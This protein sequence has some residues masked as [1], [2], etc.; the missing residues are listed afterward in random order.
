MSEN[1]QIELK[2]INTEEP[3]KKKKVKKDVISKIMKYQIVAEDKEIYSHLFDLFKETRQ[4]LNNTVNFMYEWSELKFLHKEKYGNY[5]QPNEIL[6]NKRNSGFYKSEQGYIDSILAEKYIK[7]LSSN[8]TSAVQKAVQHWKTNYKD[9][10][11][12]TKTI[13]FYKASNKIYLHNR[14]INIYQEDKEYYIDVSLFSNIY[15]KEKNFKSSKHLFKLIVGDNN[16]KTIV[17]RILNEEYGVGES[18]LI[19]DKKNKK[20]FV[21]L[22]YQFKKKETTSDEYTNILGVN[23]GLRFAAYI[24]INKSKARFKIVG[25]E[26]EA[27]RKQVDS[28]I[29]KK[30]NQRNVAGDGS[31]N[32]GKSTFLK[33]VTNIRKQTSNFTNL[34][35]HRYSKYIVQLAVRYKCKEIRLENLKGMNQKSKYLRSWSYYDIRQKIIYKAKE[36][37]IKVILIDPSYTTQT[38]SQCEHISQDNLETRK[39]FICKNCDFRTEIDYNAALNIANPEFDKIKTVKEARKEFNKDDQITDEKVDN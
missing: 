38:C 4:V 5:P 8:R 21:L 20:F 16:Q 34:T 19:Y 2:D 23:M 27:F 22:T 32:R 37:G 18:Q 33:S 14:S 15:K 30:R 36:A 1:K 26:I 6:E 13:P 29:L 31:K 25:G 17:N 3:K 10:L 39:L 12:G 11:I 28:R 24:A 7:N 9:I 35:N